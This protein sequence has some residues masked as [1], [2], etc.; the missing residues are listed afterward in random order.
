MTQYLRIVGWEQYQ[1][2]KDRNP[3]WI[4]LHR[5]LLTSETWVSSSNDERVLAIT[6]MM[7]A[8]ASGN[9]IKADARYIQRVAYL[10]VAPDWSGLVRLGF[11]E[12]IEETGETGNASNLLASAR[13]ETETETEVVVANATTPRKR[14]ECAKAHRIPP[15]WMPEKPFPSDVA[16]LVAQWPPGRLEREQAGFRDYWI[17]RIRDAA[18]SDWDRTWWNRIRDQHDRVMKDN[19]HGRSTS[20]GIDEGPTI[21]AA[22]EF[23]RLTG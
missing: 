9:K 1:H 4:K 13:P 2:Y 8:A 11:V 14:S 20:N 18:R 19:R 15:D 17:A 12:V 22:R 6:L 10:D 16:S 7:L 21:A 23:L 3:P 5:E